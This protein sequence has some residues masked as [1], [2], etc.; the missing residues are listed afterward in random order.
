MQKRFL[1]GGA[2]IIVLAIVLAYLNMQQS[3]SVSQMFPNCIPSKIMAGETR[4][5]DLNIVWVQ[6]DD[7]RH[8]KSLL[9]DKTLAALNADEQSGFDV[10]TDKPYV[11]L[12]FLCAYNLQSVNSKSDYEHWTQYLKLNA[13]YQDNSE[14]IYIAS[15]QLS[16]SD[17]RLM[18]PAIIM[19]DENIKFVISTPL[20]A[21]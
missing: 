14:A 5:V 10:E 12:V 19:H 18:V 8:A 3:R 17:I 7:I 11:S 16:Q 21:Q 6:Y 15:Y 9:G 1:W 2:A 4:P 20:A 13:E